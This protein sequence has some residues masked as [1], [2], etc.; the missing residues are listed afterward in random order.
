MSRVFQNRF[1]IICSSIGS[2]VIGFQKMCYI[3]HLLQTFS[4][5]SCVNLYFEAIW[6]Y[7]DDILEKNLFSKHCRP[8]PDLSQVEFKLSVSQLVHELGL[9]RKKE[10]NI[11]YTWTF[12]LISLLSMKFFF[13]VQHWF[14]SKSCFSWLY[15]SLVKILDQSN[16]LSLWNRM[17]HWVKLPHFDALLDYEDD[18]WWQ[19][20]WTKCCRQCP[21]FSK[22][23]FKLSVAQLVHELH[24]F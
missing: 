21:W 6:G 2:C 23:G 22:T 12:R 24:A 13:I 4:L 3:A 15:L 11:A 7:E 19:K 16:H 18:I 1:Q 8:C 20:F 17:R 5:V 9:F 14:W 10:L